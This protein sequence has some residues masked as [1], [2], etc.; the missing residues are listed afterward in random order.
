MKRHAT[1]CRRLG[2][3]GQLL[4]SATALLAV[5]VGIPWGLVAS[6]GMPWPSPAT[7]LPDLADRLTEPISDPFLIKLLALIAWA[8][9]AAFMATL[10]REACWAL[11]Q[12]PTLLRDLTEVRIRLDALPTHRAAAGF[13][14]ATLVFAL[15]TM[16]RPV[17]AHAHTTTVSVPRPAT[18]ATAAAV[19]APAPA[20]TS[21]G[22]RRQPAAQPSTLPYTVVSGDTLWDIARTH[23]GD[24]LHWPVIYQLNCHRI[25]SDGHR[26]GD[27]DQLSP[28]WILHLP[29]AATE[30]PTSTAPT[31]ATPAAPATTTS[32]QPVNPAPTPPPVAPT[33]EHHGA[34]TPEPQPRQTSPARTSV[35]ED[36]RR[37]VRIDVG[38]AS[39]IGITT[40]AGIA[41]AVAF[42]RAH[43]RRRR[44]PD[45]SAS[46]PPLS[47]AVRAAR[48]AH[49]HARHAATMAAQQPFADEAEP[50]DVLIERP[51]PAQPAAAGVIV[52]AH[53]AGQE[54]SADH[55]AVPGGIALTGPGADAAARALAISVLSAAERLRPAPPPVRLVT[56]AATAHRLLADVNDRPMPT[57]TVTRDLAEALNL[58]EQTLLHHARLADSAGAPGAECSP[59]SAHTAMDV[60]ICDLDPQHAARLVAVA[61]RAMPARL[62][63]IVVNPDSWP[64]QVRLGEDGTV[65]QTTGPAAEP[66]AGARMFT[67]SPQP[68]AELLHV[69]RAA[70]GHLADHPEPQTP[71]PPPPRHV[72]D[73]TPPAPSAPT[74]E[75]RPHADAASAPEPSAEDTEAHP[76][77]PSQDPVPPSPLTRQPLQQ[78]SWAPIAIEIL[79]RFRIRATEKEKEFGHGMREETRE[80]LALLAAHPKGIRGEKIADML[81]LSPDPD[82]AA[83]EMGNLRRAVRRSLRQATGAQHAAFI[84]RVGDRDLLDRNL[85]ATD[86]AAFTDAMQRARQTRDEDVRIAALREAVAAYGGPLCEGADYSWADEAREALHRQAIDTLMLLADH[87]AKAQ[88]HPDRALA[89]LDQAAEWDRYN[90]AVYQCVIRLQR[91]AGRD[92]AAHRTYG[93]LKRRLAEI[94]VAPD[95]VSTALIQRQRHPAAAH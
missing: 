15:A 70:Y 66:L 14:V 51:F 20:R 30:G 63:V 40:A 77:A 25:Q 68:A 55:L 37:G 88:P 95:H 61:Q 84:V 18:A 93:L 24:P 60:L 67:L 27:P 7:S 59:E 83:R 65:T 43:E 47:E 34:P 2:A 39:A 57:W 32:T 78:A 26:L 91:A 58:A 50:E 80:F 79:G 87:E 13:L 72:A 81:R 31:S 45:L 73:A 1:G 90:E 89:L 17:T 6:A 44:T 35:R 41:A 23:L 29:H 53:R 71:H 33:P 38:P 69:L 75:P 28:G 56:P 76:P 54:L 86:F 36:H 12:L 19:P 82:Q 48:S 94:G 46:P 9:W 74:P 64:S 8:C 11:R 85:I 22:E 49:L 16:W 3:L 10:V 4:L 92:D 5:T 21:P 42:A 52:C 62:A